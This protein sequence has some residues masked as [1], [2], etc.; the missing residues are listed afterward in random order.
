MA[1]AYVSNPPLDA[2]VKLGKCT[3]SVCVTGAHPAKSTSEGKEVSALELAP[4]WSD[5][6]TEKWETCSDWYY[7]STIWVKRQ[8]QGGGCERDDP[9]AP[10]PQD[11]FGIGKEQKVITVPQVCLAT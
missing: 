10:L 9:L 1:M 7:L 4:V 8:A 6:P 11:R 2:R 5:T 3:A